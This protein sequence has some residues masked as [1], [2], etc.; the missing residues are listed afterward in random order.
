MFHHA[1][2]QSA[3]Q[4]I[5]P[6]IGRLESVYFVQFAAILSRETVEIEQ[7]ELC[8]HGWCESRQLRSCECETYKNLDRFSEQ[9]FKVL[10]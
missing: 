7:R 10:W 1:N 4:R 2:P 9:C 6:F 8:Q 5:E 3:F